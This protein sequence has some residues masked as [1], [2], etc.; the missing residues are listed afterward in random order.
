ML[1]IAFLVAMLFCTGVFMLLKIN[2]VDVIRE[3]YLA[4]EKRPKTIKHECK[5]LLEKSH[6]NIFVKKIRE[7]NNIL[8]NTNQGDKKEFYETLSLIC[9]LFGFWI[10]ITL[11]NIFLALVFAFAGF[12]APHMA[13]SLMANV[14]YQNLD[15]NLYTGLLLINSSYKR[16]PVFVTAVAE[17]VEYL[18]FPLKDAFEKFLFDVN[19]VSPNR[20]QAVKKLK[21]R[22]NHP[23]FRQWCD[24]VLICL[25]DHTQAGTLDCINTLGDMTD[26][27]DSI[28]EKIQSPMVMTLILAGLAVFIVPFLFVAFPQIVPSISGTVQGEVSVA[29]IAGLVLFAVARVIHVARPVKLKEGD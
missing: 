10:G 17:N 21:Q 25:N 8:E 1:S 16:N 28:K 22:I 9:C 24:N 6:K 20:E 26:A 19:Y 13:V 7:T 23:V 29:I 2:P 14:Y 11:N 15:K 3:C 18:P 27:Q 12:L 4:W 5:R